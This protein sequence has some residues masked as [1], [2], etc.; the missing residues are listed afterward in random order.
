[1]TEPS[2]PIGVNKVCA[3]VRAAKLEGSRARCLRPSP[4][5]VLGLVSLPWTC[6][7]SCCSRSVGNTCQVLRVLVRPIVSYDSGGFTQ[8]I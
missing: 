1:M 5:L 4:P 2:S 3:V 8:L 7:L 6:L